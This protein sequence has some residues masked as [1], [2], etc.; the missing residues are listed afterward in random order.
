MKTKLYSR[1]DGLLVRSTFSAVQQRSVLWETLSPDMGWEMECLLTWVGKRFSTQ[2]G[3]RNTSQHGSGNGTSQHGLGNNV[4]RPMQ[5]LRAFHTHVFTPLINPEYD[6]KT[7]LEEGYTTFRVYSHKINLSRPHYCV[8]CTR[9]EF[10]AL[11]FCFFKLCV[12]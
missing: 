4:S 1:D 9:A 5:Q 3:K 7:V 6:H 11:R 10:Y 8:S 12:R 2:V